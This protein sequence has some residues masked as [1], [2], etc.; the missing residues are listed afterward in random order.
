MPS[1]RTIAAA[2]SPIEYYEYFFPWNTDYV[3]YSVFDSGLIYSNEDMKKAA[4]LF[5]KKYPLEGL[6][7]K[8]HLFEGGGCFNQHFKTRF[9]ISF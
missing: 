6:I 8:K 2:R 7:I 9:R 1:H 3:D 5:I 4:Q